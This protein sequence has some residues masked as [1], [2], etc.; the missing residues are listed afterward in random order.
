MKVRLKTKQE[1]EL[2]RESGKILADAMNLAIERAKKAVNEK[3][4]TMELDEIVEKYIRDKGGTPAFLHYFDGDGEPFPASLCVSINDE[5]VHGIPKKDR[6]IKEGDLVSLDLGVEYKGMYTD[7]ATTVMIGEV[8]EQA[9]KITEATKKSLSAGIAKICDGARLGDYGFA[10]DEYAT[11]NGFVT[12]KGLVGHGVGHAVHE[13]PQIPNYGEKNTGLKIKENMVLALE[14]MLA[15]GDD[16]IALGE[17]EFAFV[18][19]NGSLSA[20]FEHTVVV[21]KK[22]CEVVTGGIK[23]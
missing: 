6:I 17:D 23:V 21:T 13:A 9:R 2:L 3:V 8:S 4:T 7:A 12:I 5:I 1:I 15:V 22:G 18:T 14:P 11:K 10:V 20:H 16:R 19:Y